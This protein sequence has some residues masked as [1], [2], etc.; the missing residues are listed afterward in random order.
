MSMKNL[1]LPTLCGFFLI[2]PL[3]LTGCSQKSNEPWKLV[4]SEEFDQTDTFDHSV[5]SKTP[6]SHPDWCNYMTDLDTCY[7]MEDGNLVLRGIVA[8]DELDGSVPFLTGGIW[9]KE[10]KLFGNGR[11]E[12]R[13][14]VDDATGAWPAIWLLPEKE[15]W[16]FA[17]EIDIMEHLNYDSVA[18]QTVHSNYTYN[19]GRV[20]HPKATHTHLINNNEYNIYAVERY[21]DSIKFYIN[22]T[23]TFTYPRIETDIEGQFP[24]DECPFYIVLSMQLGGVWVGEVDPNDL[25]AEM[26]VDW[27]RFYERNKEYK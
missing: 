27:I 16:P 21:N 20:G 7:A 2:T 14:K 6:R 4:W 17:G 18:Y 23:H 26:H 12:I 11:M 22:D 3:L 13:A 9:S 24:F 1:L 15:N 10:K 8:T 5:W 25:P 19:H